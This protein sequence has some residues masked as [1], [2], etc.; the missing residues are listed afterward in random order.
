MA[1]FLGSQLENKGALNELTQLIQGL[2]SLG[3]DDL[4]KR[5]YKSGP[6]QCTREF[7]C[8]RLQ[9]NV[10]CVLHLQE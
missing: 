3:C 7:G 2:D 1:C 6:I 10:P 5:A 4:K 8:K 9:K